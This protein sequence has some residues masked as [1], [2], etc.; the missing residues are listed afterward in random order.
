VPVALDVH[1]ADQQPRPLCSPVDGPP[2]PA[3][4]EEVTASAADGTEV[5]SWLVLPATTTAEPLPL[6]VF[7]HGGP[8]SSW[9]G[10]HWRWN[11]SLLAA[12]LGGAAAESATQHRL[13]PR[14]HRP[15]L[16]RLGAF[17]DE[18]VL[19]VEWV[20]PPLL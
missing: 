12:R 9:A 4:L 17:L 19:G 18:H 16:E 1:R 15:R 6:V 13:R 11:A 7:I 14:S 3:R 20:R 10:W 5:H 2:V 8:V